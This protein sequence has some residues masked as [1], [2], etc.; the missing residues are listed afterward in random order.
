M[1]LLRE[2]LCS[3]CGTSVETTSHRRRRCGA[4]ALEAKRSMSR[5]SQQLKRES[6][7]G[8]RCSNCPRP[9]RLGRKLCETCAEN[10]RKSQTAWIA[11]HPL[12]KYAYFR[13]QWLRA[14]YGITLADY[15]AM[16]AWQGGRCAICLRD[17]GVKMPLAVDHD[18][19]TDRVRGLLCSPCNSVLGRL[20][21]DPSR[22][23]AYLE[24]S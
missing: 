18:H 6:A 15:E 3:D 20:N 16:W 13:D 11:R 14:D 5:A 4:C 19:R 22:L 1:L 8:V 10:G 12:G 2:I 7:H 17:P 21:D 9:P 24:V 23:V